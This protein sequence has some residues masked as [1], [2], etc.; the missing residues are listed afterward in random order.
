MTIG[1]VGECAEGHVADT[2]PGR[3]VDP[4]E[5]LIVTGI[6]H[7]SEVGHGILDLS[8]VVEGESPVDPVGDGVIAQ[9]L[10]EETAL[11]IGAVEY[12]HLLG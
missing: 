11:G 4:S 12:R 9:L 5:G 6:N 1:E 10:L 7:Q 3:I 2:S 8:T